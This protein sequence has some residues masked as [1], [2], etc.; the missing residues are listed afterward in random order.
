MF[1][2]KNII[3]LLFIAI[4]I[5][6]CKR[7]NSP[8]PNVVLIV[9]DDLGYADLSCTGLADD[10]KTPNIDKLATSGVRF[11]QAYAH[12]VCCPARALLLT[13]RHPQ[14]SGVN[15]WV[16]GNAKEKTGINMYLEEITLAE[17][18]KNAGYSTA[19]LGTGQYA[20]GCVRQ[21][22]EPGGY[23]LRPAYTP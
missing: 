7:A 11:T 1:A 17:V 10:V 14:R 8:D 13:G 12:T 16:Q 6:T 4:S 20:R 23:G 19:L 21:E 18:L 2:H 3:I 22:I 5:F 15:T 9:V